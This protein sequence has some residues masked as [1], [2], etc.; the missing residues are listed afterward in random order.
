MVRFLLL[1]FLLSTTGWAQPFQTVLMAPNIDAYEA[2]L[3]VA[4]AGVAVGQTTSFPLTG[5]GNRVLLT[6]YNGNGTFIWNRVYPMLPGQTA[7]YGGIDVK[8]APASVGLAAGYYVIGNVRKPNGPAVSPQGIFVTR[9][10]GMG[11]VVWHREFIPSPN[12]QTNVSAVSLEVMNDGGPILVANVTHTPSG[13]QAIM[14]ARFTPAGAIM[15]SNAYRHLGCQGQVSSIRAAESAKDV[16]GAQAAVVPLCTGQTV[17]SPQVPEAIVVT[18]DFQPCD[19]TFMTTYGS[20]RRTFALKINE[21]GLEVW[22]FAYPSLPDPTGSDGGHDLVQ[23]PNRNFVVAGRINHTLANGTGQTSIYSFEVTPVGALVCGGFHASTQGYNTFARGITLSEKQGNVVVAGP[24]DSLGTRRIMLA[25]LG[26]TC[27]PYLWSN[28]YPRAAPATVA[29]GIDRLVGQPSTYFVT[30][31]ALTNNNLDAF[32]MRTNLLGQTP[33]CPYVPI[34]LDRQPATKV[35]KLPY[36]QQAFGNWLPVQ[37]SSI[38]VQPSPKVCVQIGPNPNAAQLPTAEADIEIALYPNPSAQ[39]VQ[40]SFLGEH[41]EGVI[42][43]TD[44]MG[45][46]LTSVA[47]KASDSQMFVDIRGLRSGMYTVRVQQANGLI[48]SARLLKEM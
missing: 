47:F 30:A 44:L 39:S 6:R 16:T 43:V 33:S 15:W 23:L 22:R 14:A 40:V 12:L 7:S 37:I 5:S 2:A 21:R 35:E 4:P 19:Q 38:P 48:R 31:N 10:T 1:G 25:E 42:D 36:C 3:A 29:E 18:G 28:L 26:P 8:V 46:R 34:K 11:V 32:A 13:S 20:N 24:I 45:N 41:S 17:N 9:L 27:S